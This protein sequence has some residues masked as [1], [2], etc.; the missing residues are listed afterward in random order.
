VGRVDPTE[1]GRWNSA[2]PVELIRSQ[3]SLQVSKAVLWGSM[4]GN[5]M[6]YDFSGEN[7][8]CFVERGY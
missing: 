6:I 8:G 3:I 4:Q 2:D 1:V 5:S 7:L